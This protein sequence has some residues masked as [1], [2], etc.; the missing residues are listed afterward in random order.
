MACTLIMTGVI[1]TV[2][3]VHYPLLESVG[4]ASFP[5]YHGRHT[6]RI[7][8]L[9]GPLMGAEMVTGLWMV[10]DPPMGLGRDVCILGACLLALIWLSTA[11]IQV[12]QHRA[13][14]AGLEP[15]TVRALVLG[16]W[17]RTGA[18]TARAILLLWSLPI[19]P[20]E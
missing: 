4:N 16:N 1:W 15:R 3:H 2:Q 5:E 17:I 18:W 8:L 7:S 9:V 6:A 19:A 12:P 10:V 11:L 14:A 13:L 20:G